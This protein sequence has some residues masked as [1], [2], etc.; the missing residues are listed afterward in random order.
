MVSY[1]ITPANQVKTNDTSRIVLNFR[2]YYAYDDGSPNMVSAFQENQQQV[3]CWHVASEFTR[4]IH[5]VHCKCCSIKRVIMQMP[6]LD[7]SF[8]Y[9]KMQEVCPEN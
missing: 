9:G 1:L 4:L 7:F 6:T 5:S 8:V 3:R 2:N